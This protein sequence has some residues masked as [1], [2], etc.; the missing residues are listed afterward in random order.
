MK[1][2]SQLEVN[3]VNKLHI[4]CKDKE[5]CPKFNLAQNGLYHV[6]VMVVSG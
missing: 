1:N 6:N 4:K 3:K 5:N 2:V